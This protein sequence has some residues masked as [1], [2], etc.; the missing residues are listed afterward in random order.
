M[1]QSLL[2]TSF[3]LTGLLSLLTLSEYIISTQN[4]LTS[5]LQARYTLGGLFV[6]FFKSNTVLPSQYFE[7]KS[8]SK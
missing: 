6:Y 3:L 4:Y 2:L 1:F 7:F 8:I 5:T